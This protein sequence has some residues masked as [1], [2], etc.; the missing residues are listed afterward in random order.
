VVVALAVAVVVHRFIVALICVTAWKSHWKKLPTVMKRKFVYLVGLTA[1]VVVEMVQSL[2]P[3]LKLAQLVM[4]LVRLELHRAFSRC[5]RLVRD[6]ADLANIFLS[7]AKNVMAPEK[8]SL[9]KR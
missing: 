6:A 4:V 3:K 8:L 5:S 7:L 1:I 2:V 9:R